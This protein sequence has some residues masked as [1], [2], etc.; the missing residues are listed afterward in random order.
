MKQFSKL[1]F[2]GLLGLVDRRFN[3]ETGR[4]EKSAS[5]L[6]NCYLALFLRITFALRLCF[7][8]FYD[9]EDPIQLIIG[10]RTILFEI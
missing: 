7:S 6:F 3:F 1:K 2:L 10:G 9:R 8:S 5:A 4:F